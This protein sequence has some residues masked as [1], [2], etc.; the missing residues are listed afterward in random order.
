MGFL[1]QKDQGNQSAFNIAGFITE[2][3]AVVMH[4]IYCINPG[5]QT[6]YQWRGCCRSTGR[7]P[8]SDAGAIRPKRNADFEP[9]GGGRT[10]RL[11]GLILENQL[12]AAT[13]NG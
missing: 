1:P 10:A 2:E 9:I 5:T 7:T 13:S 4:R 8:D 6:E 3:S 11:S 12:V